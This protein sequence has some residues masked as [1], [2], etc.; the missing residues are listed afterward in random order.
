VIQRAALGLAI[1]V[2]QAMASQHAGNT[3]QSVR[4]LRARVAYSFQ[5]SRRAS[6]FSLASPVVPGPL[7]READ[8]K[9][10]DAR[11]ISR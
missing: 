3:L 2:I 6:F 4:T 9:I 5:V 10:A 7:S 1:A 11:L 8:L